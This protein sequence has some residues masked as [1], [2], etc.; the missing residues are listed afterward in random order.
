MHEFKTC[1]KEIYV[2]KENKIKHWD[3]FS[4]LL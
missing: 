1:I 4:S 3:I 2:V